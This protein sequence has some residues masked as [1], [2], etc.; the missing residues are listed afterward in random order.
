MEIRPT[1][2]GGLVVVAV[3]EATDERGTVREFFRQSAYESIDGLPPSFP[4]VNVTHTERGGVR[5]LHGESVTKLVGVAAGEAFGAW[6]DARRE[7][8]TFGLVETMPL[9]VGVQVL[10]PPGVLNGFQS[11]SE[12]GCQYLYCFDQ[13]WRPDMPGVGGAL[14]VDPELGIPWPIEIDPS[15]PAHLSAKDA[16]LPPFSAL[17]A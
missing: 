14:A 8:P 15:N 4:Q 17:R 5:G 1:S 13:E 6:V 3:K 12:G 7:S 11:V 2:I 10:V 16:A 9:G